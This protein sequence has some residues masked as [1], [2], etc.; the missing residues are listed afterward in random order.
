MTKELNLTMQVSPSFAS[1]IIG[2][3]FDAIYIFSV[4][5]LAYFVISVS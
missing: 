3:P 5:C 2:I 1:R 4:F